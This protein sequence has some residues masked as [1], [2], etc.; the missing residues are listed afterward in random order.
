MR[1]VTNKKFLLLKPE[2]IVCPPF[3]ARKHYDDL[4]I[5]TLADNIS[6]NG[7]IEP[8][9]VRKNPVGSFEVVSGIRRLKAA[10]LIGLRRIP[11]ILIT[12]D[13]EKAE[14][15]SL[16]ENTQRKYLNF[17]EEAEAISLI[18]NRFGTDYKT[19][20][21]K[22]GVSYSSLL[23]RLK[24]IKLDSSVKERII[25]EGL[26]ENHARY[27]SMI[28]EESQPFF[29]DKIVSSSLNESATK[30]MVQ[31]YLLGFEEPKYE[32]EEKGEPIGI[33]KVAVGDIRLFSNSISKLVTTMKCSGIDAFSQKTEGEKYIEYKI[34]IPKPQAENYKQ[35][36]LV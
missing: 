2:K 8:L 34:R 18:K 17:F 29:I 25:S 16:S 6:A 24:L 1:N 11:C 21:E 36:R 9:I 32:N 20:A 7:I 31:K 30:L 28:D 23:N 4:S 33:K 10:N 27:I 12:A 19:I 35:L 14:I 26:S 3:S 5:K 13:D 22:I 15:I